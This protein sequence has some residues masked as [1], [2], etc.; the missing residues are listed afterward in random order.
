[1][2][3]STHARRAAA[4]LVAALLAAAPGL[5]KAGGTVR[6]T[7]SGR[8]GAGFAAGP[9]GLGVSAKAPLGGHLALQAT[10]LG[11]GGTSEAGYRRGGFAV[12]ADLLYRMP[13]LADPGWG[14][15]AWN[16]GGGLA[17]GAGRP[18]TDADAHAYGLGMS[19]VAGLELDL[20][21]VPIDLAL[22]LRPS[23][24]LPPDFDWDP[25]ALEV[26]ARFWW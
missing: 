19:A 1:M 21:P 4:S 13:A 20:R 26:H 11:R 2:K 18:G 10:A 12:G 7:E 15:L 6:M 17:L 23:F 5:A 25:L 9:A 22:E 16:L 8:R 14:L 3:P 24:G